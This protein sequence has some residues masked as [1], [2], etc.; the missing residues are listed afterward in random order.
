MPEAE[1]Y[2]GNDALDGDPKGTRGWEKNMIRE[3]KIHFN[4]FEFYIVG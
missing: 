1:Y 2:F 3:E 4:A